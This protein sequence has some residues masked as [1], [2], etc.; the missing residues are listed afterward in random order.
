[1][2]GS[3]F[4]LWRSTV[5]CYF[6]LPNSCNNV[7][8]VQ[9]DQSAITFDNRESATKK[10]FVLFPFCKQFRCC[11]TEGDELVR[12]M[13]M[14]GLE[15]QRGTAKKFGFIYF[16]KMNCA[17]LVPISTFMF[18]PPNFLQ[19]NRQTDERN[20][21]RSQKHECRNWDCSC[22]VPFLVIFVSKCSLLCFCS[23]GR[24]RQLEE[25][26]NKV[27]KKCTCIVE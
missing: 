25:D 26:K 10:F 22:A 16:Q 9:H 8:S 6:N 3:G 19:Q 4:G 20:I 14:V 7:R 18:G 1:M 5:I 11:S 23:G 27:M 12:K 13:E 21:Y 24:R 2:K 17:A 15:M